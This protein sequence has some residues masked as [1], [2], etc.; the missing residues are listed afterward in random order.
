MADVSSS[1]L[2]YN[3]IWAESLGN[4]D[5]QSRPFP[6]LY[7]HNTTCLSLQHAI[8]TV[9]ALETSL[10][11]I[12]NVLDHPQWLQK[13]MSEA[14]RHNKKSL[15]P[16]ITTLCIHFFPNVSPE[17]TKNSRSSLSGKSTI[18]REMSWGTW[19]H[20]N[21]RPVADPLELPPY[22]SYCQNHST[23]F[24]GCWRI[25]CCSRGPGGLCRSLHF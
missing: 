14:F 25:W 7:P 21:G 12:R 9:L 10:W 22:S 16:Q 24:P 18:I 19:W 5:I 4:L 17:A 13:H 11:Q 1:W 2:M 6:V 3:P 20:W 23:C 8:L 15:Q